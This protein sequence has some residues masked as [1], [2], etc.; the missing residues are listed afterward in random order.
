[1]SDFHSQLIKKINELSAQPLVNACTNQFRP[2]VSRRIKII[3]F[4]QLLTQRLTRIFCYLTGS[5]ITQY[6]PIVTIIDRGNYFVSNLDAFCDVYDYLNDSYSK[7]R[8]INY[9]AFNYIKSYSSRLPFDY[10]FFNKCNEK[11]IQ[12]S[13]ESIPNFI[14]D[15]IKGRKVYIPS[16]PLGYT[17]N[18]QMEQYAYRDWLRVEDGDIVLDCGAANGDT[19]IYFTAFGAKKVYSFEF[20]QSNI[21]KF[22]DVLSHNGSF[23]NNISIVKKALWDR[24][25][26]ELCFEDNGN[27]STVSE[28]FSAQENNILTISIDDFLNDEGSAVNFIKMDIEGAELKALEGARESIIKYK[29]KL[30]ICVYHKDV[31][32][33]EIP[34]FILSLG[35]GY[36]FNFDYYTD[37]GAEAVLYAKAV[38]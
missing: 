10:D 12:L 5:Y 11:A 19:A 9:I 36:T 15:T 1:M 24:S 14:Q 30:A 34:N 38:N 7:E 33:V 23:R 37:T 20:L 27:A 17:I 2:Y 32:L 8:Y 26:I 4:F 28:S 35:C 29:P 31:D 3:N 21:N 6:K 16:D 25:G 18:F 13:S 22:E